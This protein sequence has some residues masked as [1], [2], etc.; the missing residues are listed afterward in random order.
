MLLRIRH[1]VTGMRLVMY[2]GKF[3]V[4]KRWWVF[5]IKLYF[6]FKV[7]KNNPKWWSKRSEYFE[8]DCWVDEV[9]IAK[10]ALS[11][12]LDGSI[13]KAIIEPYR[14]TLREYVKDKK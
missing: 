9:E 13:K 8:S 10:K 2:K 4:E 1:G 14:E 3:G 11:D 6:D 5:G 7:S 12:I